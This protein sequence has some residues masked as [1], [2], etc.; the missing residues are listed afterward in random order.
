MLFAE[1]HNLIE[2]YIVIVLMVK[3][4]KVF[5]FDKFVIE[6]EALLAEKVELA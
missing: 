1:E 4:E 5:G 2:L 6:F 3:L